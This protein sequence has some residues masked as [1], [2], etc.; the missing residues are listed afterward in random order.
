MAYTYPDATAFKAYFTRDFPYGST[1]EQVMDADINKAIDEAKFNFNEAL[2]GSQAEF[3]IGF[4]YLTAHYLVS[5]LQAS[6]QGIAGQYNW[7][8]TSKSA[9]NVSESFQIPDRILNNPEFAMFSK[10]RYGAKFLSLIMPRIIGQIFTVCGRT[11][12]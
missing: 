2:F 9:G 1:T 4:L 11:K 12:P 6:S 5:D 3:N 10:T 8:Q 7:L